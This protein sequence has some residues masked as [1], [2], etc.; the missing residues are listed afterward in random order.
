MSTLNTNTQNF[1][2]TPELDEFR[3]NKK[4][5]AV[6]EK[7]TLTALSFYP[8]LKETYIDFIFKRS[9]KSSVMQAQPVFSTLLNQRKHRTYRI[10]I[11][12]LFKLTHTAI[13]IHQIPDTIMI[14]WIGHEL[15]H[16]MDYERRSNMGMIGFGIGYVFSPSYVKSVEQIADKFAVDHGLGQYLIETKRFILNHAH[17]PQAYKDKIARLY[18]S[19]EAIVDQV[20]KLEEERLKPKPDL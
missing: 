11:S 5:P 7:N 10:N 8:E 20:K 3:T 1:G 18:V 4:I 17:L 2:V 15:G 9:I 14:G 6:I 16:I 13:P 12:S 19:P